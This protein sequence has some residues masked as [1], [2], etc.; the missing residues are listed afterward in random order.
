[1]PEYEIDPPFEQH[2]EGRLRNYAEQGVQPY[3][4]VEIAHLAAG[5]GAAPS[6]GAGRL[7][8]AP[9][10]AVLVAALTLVGL[11]AVAFAAGWFPSPPPPDS[12]PSPTAIAESPSPSPSAPGESPTVQP[13][14]PTPETPV[15][16]TRPPVSPGITPSP[17]PT[18]PPESIPPTAPPLAVVGE[19]RQLTDFPL[20]DGDNVVVRD[21]TAG[22]PGYLAVGFISDGAGNT[23]G[24]RAWTSTDGVSWNVVD[25]DAF[26]GAKLHIAVEHLGALYAFGPIPTDDPDMPDMGAYNIWRSDDGQTWELLPQ[27]APFGGTVELQGAT[28]A[29][30]TLVAWGRHDVEVD[31]ETVV[32][33]GIWSWTPT[34]GGDWQPADSLPDTHDVLRMSY[35]NGVLVALGNNRSEDAPWR[36]IWYSTDEARTWAAGDARFIDDPLVTLEDIAAGTDPAPID[37]TGGVYATVGWEGR[38]AE[39][40]PFSLGTTY[41]RDWFTGGGLTGYVPYQWERIAT[42]P[43]GFLVMGTEYRFETTPCAP[44]PCRELIP[45][46]ARMWTANTVGTQ[47][48][49]GFGGLVWD[50]ASSPAGALWFYNAVA[51]DDAGVV[52]L[53]SDPDFNRQMW[54]APLAAP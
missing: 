28:S 27:P 26:I 12:S 7:V 40:H 41:E 46:A 1:M 18:V 52:I 29:G 11:T 35:A 51:V 13:T 36:T 21:V 30:E 17:S 25:S 22:G 14:E 38:E 31:G 19:W 54:F 3:D 16:A 53:A 4:A 9:V 32:R 44:E 2:V 5:G 10:A 42:I 23:G 43:G 34:G 49:D 24:G 33:P 39:T 50:E 37:H 15:P 48:A 6:G 45:V 8:P 47:W 20:G